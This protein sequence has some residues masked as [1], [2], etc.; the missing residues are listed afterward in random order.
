MII[1]LTPYLNQCSSQ[2]A[3]PTVMLAI[4]KTE[5][6][7][8]PLA[9]GINKDT[10]GRKVR[11][12]YQAKSYDQA[13]QWLD[14]LEKNDYN[15]DV[16]VAQINIKNIHK[17]GYRAADALDI[18]LNLQMASKILKGNYNSA[19]SGSKNPQQAVRD[20]I[21]AYNTGNYH[22]GYSN[23]YVNRVLI[24]YNKVVMASR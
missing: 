15:F 19:L 5:S 4:V 7:G 16:G 20:A 24:N 8:N 13:K 10:H 9:I 22:S 12:A 11:L 17:Y 23:G 2:N 14:Y 1:D 3:H 18:C 6:G 21:S